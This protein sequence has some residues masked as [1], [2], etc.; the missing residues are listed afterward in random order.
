M[1]RDVNQSYVSKYSVSVMSFAITALSVSGLV[2]GVSEPWLD[3]D[4][5]IQFPCSP[6]LQHDDTR[7]RLYFGWCVGKMFCHPF[8]KAKNSSYNVCGGGYLWRILRSRMSQR[9]SVGVHLPILLAMVRHKHWFAV[10]DIGTRA[11]WRGIVMLKDTT[12]DVN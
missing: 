8:C 6:H 2:A 10:E 11:V 5:L 12:I 7:R 3:V 1:S 4:T 9:C